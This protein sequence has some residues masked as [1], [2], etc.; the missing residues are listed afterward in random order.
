MRYLNGD[1]TLLT[2]IHS[3]NLAF[4]TKG[5]LQTPFLKKLNEPRV[6]NGTAVKTTSSSEMI[7]LVIAWIWL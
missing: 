5:N 4:V 3:D 2:V 1:R 6:V 7:Q